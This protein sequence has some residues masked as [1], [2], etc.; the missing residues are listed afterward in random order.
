MESTYE[1][2]DKLIG[3]NVPKVTDSRDEESLG[4][5]DTSNVKVDGHGLPLVPQPSN[6]PDDPLVSPIFG[7]RTLTQI[8]VELV[9]KTE[10]VHLPSNQLACSLGAN[11]LCSDQSRIRSAREIFP[12]YHYRGILHLDHLH[13]ILGSWSNPLDTLRQYLWTASD[14]PAWELDWRNHEHR[15]CSLYDVGWSHDYKS[16]RRSSSWC[17]SGNWRRYYM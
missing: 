11:E 5:E 2:S 13:R 17:N 15:R 16:N 14:L 4:Q 10:I 12:H 3:D 6:S 7:P 8:H 1:K 9:S